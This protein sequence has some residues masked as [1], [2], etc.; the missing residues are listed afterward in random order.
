MAKT[1]LLVVT[2]NFPPLTGGMERLLKHIVDGLAE[3]HDVTLIG[4]SGCA[5]FCPAGVKVHEC[6]ANAAGF[7]LFAAVKGFFV[8]LRHRHLLVLGGSGLVAPVT[9]LLARLR[10]S[11]SAVHVHGLDLV[12]QSRVYQALFV[13]FIRRHD[14]V[15]ANSGNTRRLAIDKGCDA[16]RVRVLHPGTEFPDAAVVAA[17]RDVDLGLGDSKI[18][19]SVGRMIKRKGLAEFLKKAWPDVHARIG[20]VR[21]LVVGD[22]P[23]NAL[24]RD[25]DGAEA[26]VSAVDACPPDS[27]KFLG[28]V[29]NATLWA[30]LR[31]G[32]CVGIP[33]DQCRRRRR[34]L[35]H[36]CDRGRSLRYADGGLC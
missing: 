1:R 14:L 7:L 22:S 16:A 35:R 31:A 36:G 17:A 28:G 2:R 30:L 27:V 26:I 18:C 32:G 24:V 6:P 25:R 4:P 34:G 21:L 10:G 29:D 8:S 23:E 3:G 11:R 33:P 12:V 19:L 9:K 15:I 20:N 5:E 13:P